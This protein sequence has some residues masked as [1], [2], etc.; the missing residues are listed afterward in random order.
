MINVRNVK[1]SILILVSLD[2]DTKTMYNN[3]P[4][5]EME[6]HVGADQYAD[7]TKEKRIHFDT[8]AFDAALNNAVAPYLLT[9]TSK[10]YVEVQWQE[11]S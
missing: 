4:E 7:K 1:G 3:D 9:L 11:I 2:L 6:M 5:T 10:T 8:T